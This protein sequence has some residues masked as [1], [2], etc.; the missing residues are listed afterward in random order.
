MGGHRPMQR[1]HRACSQLFLL[2]HAPP[3]APVPPCSWTLQVSPR[4]SGRKPRPV[5]IPIFFLVFIVGS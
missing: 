3:R 1:N 5:E 4:I 2:Q